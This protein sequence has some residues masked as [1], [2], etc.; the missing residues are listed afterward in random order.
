[1]VVLDPD[2]RFLEQDDGAVAN[3]GELVLGGQRV[4]AAV[5]LQAETTLIFALARGDLVAEAEVRGVDEYLVEYVVL[6]L[7]APKREV[8]DGGL[9]EERLSLTGDMSRV[10]GEGFLRIGLDDVADEADSRDG[11][12]RIDESRRKVG[13]EG[14]VAEFDS[15]EAGEVRAIKSEAD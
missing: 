14:E 6:E 9:L 10:A 4:I 3:P 7:G 1:M 15:L 13:Y 2:A 5:R 12:E 11:A 8:G